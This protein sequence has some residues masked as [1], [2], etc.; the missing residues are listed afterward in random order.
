MSAD[1]FEFLCS[2]GLSRFDLLNMT[3]IIREGHGTWYHA[4]LMRALHRLLPHADS[5]NLRRL[6]VA[7]PG[8]VAAYTLWYNDPSALAAV[9]A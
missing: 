6:S 2:D 3:K 5:E 9:A 8:S 1:E 7:Y 4:E